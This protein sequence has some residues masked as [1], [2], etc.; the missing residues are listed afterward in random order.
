MQLRAKTNC[1]ISSFYQLYIISITLT[2]GPV[3]QRLLERL[4]VVK[5]QQRQRRQMKRTSLMIE[6]IIKSKQFPL[7]INKSP[8]VKK[9]LL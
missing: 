8:A 3:K 2:T 9:W 6:K 1:K 4:S 7:Y 5:M